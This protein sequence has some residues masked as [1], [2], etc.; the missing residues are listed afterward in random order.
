MKLVPT[1]ELVLTV[2]KEVFGLQEVNIRILIGEGLKP[3][4]LPAVDPSFLTTYP[5]RF[6]LLNQTEFVTLYS[7]CGAL[8][9][10]T[11]KV[12][13][14]PP[15]AVEQRGVPPAVLFMKKAGSQARLGQVGID[16]LLTALMETTQNFNQ[17]RKAML[18]G[19][20]QDAMDM[21]KALAE[22]TSDPIMGF[23]AESGEPIGESEISNPNDSLISMIEGLCKSMGIPQEVLDGV[24][25]GSINPAD[26]GADECNCPGC[27]AL[28]EMEGKSNGKAPHGN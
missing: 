17:I 26:I 25:N 24:K 20:T 1:Q 23:N 2:M 7:L 8:D 22:I 14:M 5:N 27:T 15:P 3:Q 11:I 18:E 28:H 21:T 6:D 12:A 19:R 13:L 10:W 4:A 16:W 9:N